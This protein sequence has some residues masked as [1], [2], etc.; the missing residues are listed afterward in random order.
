MLSKLPSSFVLRIFHIFLGGIHL[1]EAFF[2]GVRIVPPHFLL[3]PQPVDDHSVFGLFHVLCARLVVDE[4]TS[5]ICLAQTLIIEH[6]IRLLDVKKDISSVRIR[7]LVRVVLQCEFPVGA[8][9]FCSC[10]IPLNAQSLV[11]ILGPPA[12]LLCLWPGTYRSG[13]PAFQELYLTRKFTEC[14]IVL[15]AGGCD[16]PFST[17]G[18]LHCLLEMPGAQKQFCKG[19][20]ALDKLGKGHPCTHCSGCLRH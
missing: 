10:G 16:E 7:V 14:L 6:L 18:L 20:V 1:H 15:I 4:L 19:G 9:D 17:V 11:M 3:S 12:L 8:L 5:V 13:K 2:T